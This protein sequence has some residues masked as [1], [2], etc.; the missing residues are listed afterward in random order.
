[1]PCTP[2][3]LRTRHGRSNAVH[4]M[5]GARPCP[6]WEEQ[7]RAH[8]GENSFRNSEFYRCPPPPPQCWLLLL[9][10]E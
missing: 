7:C 1:M 5:G 6:P 2:W 10:S 8:H 9:V 4:T 3:P